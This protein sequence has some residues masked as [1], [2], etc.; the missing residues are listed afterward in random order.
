MGS[1]TPEN[2]SRLLS[3]FS[4]LLSLGSGIFVVSMVVMIFLF[5]WSLKE[6]LKNAKGFVALFVLTI[7]GSLTFTQMQNKNTVLT[8]ASAN[9]QISQAEVIQISNNSFKITIFTTSPTNGYLEYQDYSQPEKRSIISTI[10]G[11]SNKHIFYIYN[12]SNNG[13]EA[14]MIVNKKRIIFNNQPIIIIPN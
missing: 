5:K 8:Q 11:L 1:I 4:I 12:V 7:L 10:A 14:V 13:G 3:L 2:T 6:T 9:I